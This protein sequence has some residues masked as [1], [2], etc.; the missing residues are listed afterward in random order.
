V[1]P[2]D[3]VLGLAPNARLQRKIAA[4]MHKAKGQ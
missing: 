3:D 2:V 4:Q 1:R